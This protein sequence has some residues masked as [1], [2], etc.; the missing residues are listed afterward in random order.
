MDKIPSDVGVGFFSSIIG[1]FLGWWGS[2]IKI[3]ELEDRVEEISHTVR[4]ADTCD[5]RTEG[6]KARLENIE[7]MNEEMRDD[8][9]LL[10]RGLNSG[11]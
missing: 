2:K 3:K 5:E 9:K 8:I 4:F 7:K 11:R 1:F 10:L 6:I